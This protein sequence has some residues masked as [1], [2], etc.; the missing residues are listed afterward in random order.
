MISSEQPEDVLQKSLTVY[1]LNDLNDSGEITIT[2]DVPIEDIP[3]TVRMLLN[4]EWGDELL[5]RYEGA[6]TSISIP[7]ST[8]RV[9]L[10]FEPE[11]S[12]IVHEH[13]NKYTF[14]GIITT[15]PKVCFALVP[16]VCQYLIRIPV[17]NPSF[18]ERYY[19][20]DEY[21]R[22]FEDKIYWRGMVFK[23]Q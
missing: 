21:F 2:L 5:F 4:Y 13:P 16:D 9:Y 23:K 22:L 3:L 18:F 6:P 15:Y 7:S 20:K 8:K 1:E 14:Q 19:I 17:L 11:I 12:S 10:A